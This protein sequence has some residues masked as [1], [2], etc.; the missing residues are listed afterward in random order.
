MRTSARL[1][2]VFSVACATPV[3]APVATT[4]VAARVSGRDLAAL[5]LQIQRLRDDVRALQAVVAPR[6]AVPT[7]RTLRDDLVDVSTRVGALAEAVATGGPWGDPHEYVV[8]RAVA[9][10]DVPWREITIDEG[11]VHIVEADVNGDGGFD[12]L[13]IHLVNADGGVEIYPISIGEPGV[14]IGADP[15]PVPGR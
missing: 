2:V 5:Q 1:A 15:A 9:P 4:D 10:S 6:D 13:A 7:G 12:A 3:D 8:G 14:Q 11:G